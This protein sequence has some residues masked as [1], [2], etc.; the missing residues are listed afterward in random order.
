M[1]RIA[2]QTLSFADM[3]STGH[4]AE[5]STGAKTVQRPAGPSVLAARCFMAAGYIVVPVSSINLHILLLLP[6]VL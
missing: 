4:T 3:I 5:E 1:C 6:S 2:F